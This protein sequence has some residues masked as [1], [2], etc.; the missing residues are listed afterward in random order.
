VLTGRATKKTWKQTIKKK[1]KGGGRVKQ[2]KRKVTEVSKGNPTG[3]RKG[4]TRGT[5]P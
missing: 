5:K 4:V 2:L 1:T 3:T